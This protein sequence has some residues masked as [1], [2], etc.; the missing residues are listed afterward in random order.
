[1]RMSN[2]GVCGNGFAA[3][4]V[5][6]RSRSLYLFDKSFLSWLCTYKP[7]RV[8]VFVLIPANVLPGWYSAVSYSLEVCMT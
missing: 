2:G 1:M 3:V 7:V 5:A 4:L 6:D 8:L